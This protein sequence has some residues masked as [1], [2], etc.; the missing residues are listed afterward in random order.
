M[1]WKT[2]T[3]LHWLKSYAAMSYEKALANRNR[4][5][6]SCKS[7]FGSWNKTNGV[8]VPIVFECYAERS[9]L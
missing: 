2:N 3:E 7:G 6:N 4:S 8:N 9:F 1:N 5:G